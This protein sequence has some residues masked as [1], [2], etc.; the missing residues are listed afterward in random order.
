MV[1][2]GSL[3]GAALKSIDRS[4]W[5]PD[6]STMDHA[7]PITVA[8]KLKQPKGSN[9]GLKNGNVPSFT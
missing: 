7:S 2:D 1:L 5:V 4:S 3:V 8:Y 6:F 9:P